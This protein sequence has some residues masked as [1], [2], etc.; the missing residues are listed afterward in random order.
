MDLSQGLKGLV[1]GT[2]RITKCHFVIW[3]ISFWTVQMK[4]NAH[5]LEQEVRVTIKSSL[6]VISTFA[7]IGTFVSDRRR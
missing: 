3:S 2:D 7:L 5:R 4:F 1:G 6:P